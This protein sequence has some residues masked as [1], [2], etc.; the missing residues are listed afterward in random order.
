ML[1]QIAMT[2]AEEVEGGFADRILTESLGT[3]LSIR[4]AQRFI[5]QLPLPTSGVFR[6]SG[7]S[8]CATTSRRT[9]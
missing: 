4:I 6:R 1:S 7:C 5:G 2:L 9:R 3:A 8:G